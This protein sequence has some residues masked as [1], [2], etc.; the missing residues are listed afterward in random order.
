MSLRPKNPWHTPVSA[1]KRPTALYIFPVKYSTYRIQ[2]CLLNTLKENNHSL[3][4]LIYCC[5]VSII[6]VICICPPGALI[7]LINLFLFLFHRIRNND[8]WTFKSDCFLSRYLANIFES[9]KY[10]IW[11]VWCSL[12]KY[13]H[14]QFKIRVSCV[15][16]C[17]IWCEAV[18]QC[19]HI[20]YI[21]QIWWY[22]IPVL[23]GQ[24][25]EAVFI[26]VVTS[27]LQIMPPR[28]HQKN[29]WHTPVSASIF[30]RE[31]LG[32]YIVVVYQSSLLFVYALIGPWLG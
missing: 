11:L 3:F 8:A 28:H 30:H 14:V 2:R 16:Y 4:R 12:K 23:D 32:W 6:I 26:S 18:L 9:C 19:L 15:F 20:I 5:C 22:T 7:W 31:Y 29:P 10:C 1:S 17:Q 24:R 13:L 21:Q 25:K 27:C